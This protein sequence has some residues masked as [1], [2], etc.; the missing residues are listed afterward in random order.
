[1][2]RFY[3]YINLSYSGGQ[4]DSVAI[5]QV[6]ENEG[7][8]LQ[9]GYI[10]TPGQFIKRSG[11]S[12]VGNDSGNAAIDGQYAW[13]T[14][15]GTKYFLRMV[16]GALQY[17]NSSTWTNL[18]TGFTSGLPTEFVPANG[19]LYIF[20]GTDTTHSWDGSSTTLNSCL[21]EL[22]NTTVPTGKYA[23]YWK[24]YMIV[25]GNCL[26]NSAN[27]KG[28]AYFSNLG[29][30]DTFTT[31]TDYFDIGLKDGFDGTG[32]YGIDK[33]LVLGKERS[34]HLMTGA[35]PTEWILSST[36]NNLSVIDASIGVAS[37]RSMRQVG[38][39]VWF[40][41]TDG[42][43]HSVI[44]NEQ[45]ATPL[46]G[47]VSGNMQGTLSGMNRAQISKVATEVFN[48]R[49]YVAFPDGSSTYNN[50]VIVA[51]TFITLDN[52]FNPH[53]W[54]TYTGWNPAV[55]AIYTPSS[56]PQ[57]YYGEASADSLTFQAETGTNDNDVAIDFDYQSGMLTLQAP[58][59]SKNFRFGIFSGDSGGNYDITVSQSLDGVSFSSVGMLN[60]SSGDVWDTGTWGTATW[61][62]SSEKQE[63]FS[64]KTKSNKIMIRMRN[65]AADQAVTINTYTV[66]I[67]P[68]KT[69]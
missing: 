15:G 33:Y 30:P 49:V 21:T 6:K 60:L 52:P 31:G 41:G 55:W 25:W 38:N 4:N 47:I 17:L 7:T 39:D 9:N 28:R 50:K 10:R 56:T 22:N 42:Q 43:M 66:A 11:I 26:L 29:D 40:M 3:E 8:L 2:G 45:G 36:V 24:N 44:R 57:L 46:T 20:N 65:N 5:D 54:V 58:E 48:G 59:K 62:Y 68:R 14:P 53:P 34:V 64:F 19:K 67:K 16:G 12:L 18:D 32:I 69:R 23:V 37:H 1:M 27:Y 63:K 51:D 61:G 13:T 35:N